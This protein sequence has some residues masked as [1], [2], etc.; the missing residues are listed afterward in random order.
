LLTN[1]FEGADTT[2]LWVVG[3]LLVYLRLL[4]VHLRLLFG[5]F[6]LF[7]GLLLGL[8]HLLHSQLFLVLSLVAAFI[9]RDSAAAEQAWWQLGKRLVEQAH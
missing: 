5:R 1:A 8:Q 2:G 6:V 9:G 4:L 3:L 7:F